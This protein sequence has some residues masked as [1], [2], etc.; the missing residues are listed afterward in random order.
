M[1]YLGSA[2]FLLM[3][4]GLIISIIFDLFVYDALAVP[5]GSFSCLA[6]AFALTVMALPVVMR[7]TQD[8]MLTV[9]PQLREAAAT[10]GAARSKVIQRMTWQAAR[11]GL[12]TG[13]PLAV[14][15]VSDETAPLL[16]T[17]LSNQFLRPDL[18]TTMANIPVTIKNF[19]YN[20]DLNW[21]RLAWSG[22]LKIFARTLSDRRQWK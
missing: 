19:V 12:V 6:E 9:P 10:L 3:L 11:S 8:I 14:A 21:Q 5:M 4:D 15:R 22:V 17:A 18:M 1:T 2:I 7:M 13:L 20:P 16:F